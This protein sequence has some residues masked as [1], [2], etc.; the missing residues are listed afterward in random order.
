MQNVLLAENGL[1]HACV[2][3]T[4]RSEA[5]TVGPLFSIVIRCLRLFVPISRAALRK[6][7]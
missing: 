2:H 5:A 4:K 6:P 7:I 3:P 1:R